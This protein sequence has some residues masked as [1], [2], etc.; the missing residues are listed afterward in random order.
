VSDHPLRTPFA[1]RSGNAGPCDQLARLLEAPLVVAHPLEPLDAIVV[2]GAPLAPSGALSALLAER[3]AAAAALYHAG[4]ARRVVA[5]GGV[6]GGRAA[7][8]EAAVIAEALAAAGVPDVLVEDRSRTTAQNARF[9]AELLAPL[10]ARTVWIATQPFHGRRAARLFR[11][12]GFEPR[13]WHIADSIQYRDR[14]RALR[15]LVREYLAWGKLL[16]VR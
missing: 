14:P 12:A 10:G 3:V 7:R 9:T 15:W 11:R 8:A 6:T 1:G 16:V 2:L 5:S 13:V 4:G